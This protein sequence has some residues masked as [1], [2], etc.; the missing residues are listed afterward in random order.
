[1]TQPFSGHRT[2][3]PPVGAVDADL[4]VEDLGALRDADLADDQTRVVR[5][6]SDLTVVAAAERA[7]DVA[8][9]DGSCMSSEAIA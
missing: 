3:Q 4:A 9:W 7:R 2:S 8:E 6:N 1:V 5:Y